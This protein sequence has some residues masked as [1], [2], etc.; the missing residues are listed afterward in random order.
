MSDETPKNFTLTEAE[1]TR[2]EVEPLL[3]EAMAARRRMVELD[4]QLGSLAERIQRQGGLAVSYDSAAQLRIDHDSFVDSIQAS[5][6]AIHATGCLVKDLDTGL[7]D[8]PGRFNGQEIYYCWRVGEER[9]RFYHGQDEGF[10]AR[11][12]IAP[13]DTSTGSTIQ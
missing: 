3:L 2:A 1:R 8:F 10:S 13:G 5:L 7:L 11:K 6:D 4:Q 9:I 12:P